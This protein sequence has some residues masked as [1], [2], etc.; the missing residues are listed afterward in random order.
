MFV[1]FRE[2]EREKYRCETETSTG[3]V[4]CAPTGD[5]THNLGKCPD[6]EPNLQYFGVWE[7]AP[8]K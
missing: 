8:T 2:R 6:W 7:D 3:C 4:I 5:R 1:D